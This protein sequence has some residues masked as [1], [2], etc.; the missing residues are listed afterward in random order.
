MNLRRSREDRTE[1]NLI[2]LIDVLF[3]LLIFFMVTTSFKQEA[4]LNIEL[5]EADGEAMQDQPDTTVEISIDKKGVFFINEK[6]VAQPGIDALK[7]ALDKVIGERKDIPL[8]INADGQTPHQAVITA[9]D[10][11]R[12]LG[13]L[14]LTFA[15]RGI[16]DTP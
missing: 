4:A 12:Q 8:V 11:A 10:A 9:M 13:L 16:T 1:L 15:A 2:P 6:K 7:A 5:P 3:I 14:R